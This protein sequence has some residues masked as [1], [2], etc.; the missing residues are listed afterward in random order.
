[1]PDWKQVLA[2]IVNATNQANVVAHGASDI[3][4]R[5]YLQKLSKHT[6]RN[7]IAYYSGWLAKQGIA[8]LEIGDEDKNGF[9]MAV[10]GLD[11]A[12]GLDLILHTP[13]GGIAA[14]QSIV[15]Y[16]HKMF[17]N[18]MRAVVPQIAMSAGT[19]LA[20][21]CRTVVMAKHSNLGPIDPHLNGIPAYGVIEEFKR[22]VK[23]VKARPQSAALW[24]PII[25]QYRPAF[26]GQCSHAIKWSNAFVLQ[27]LETVMFEG[28]P[29]AKKKARAIVRRLT[30]Y[31]G[32]RTHSLHLHSDE[33]QR[34]GIKVEDLEAN[35]DF[36]DLVLT[37]H[38]CY[39]HALTNGPA[40]KIIENQNGAAWVKAQQPVARQL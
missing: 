5:G 16:L 8:G 33:C 19:M 15:D 39:M 24:Q 25:A 35:S 1:M 10:H 21:S 40:F 28:D 37:V 12:K 2:E 26:L 38:H 13:G 30:D 27:Q 17:G 9:M 20:C 4:R 18:N 34:V 14:T 23:E 11:R 29:D 36:Q 31:S 32:N 3:I 6:G 7:V 22:A